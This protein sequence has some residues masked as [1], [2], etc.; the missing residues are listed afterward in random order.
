MYPIMLN[1][2]QLNIIVIGGGK[3]A[4]RKVQ[5][6]LDCGAQHITIVSDQLTPQLQS[7]VSQYQLTWQARLY[8]QGDII[9]FH[10]VLLCTN[11]TSVNQQIAQEITKEQ[12]FNDATNKEN[13]NFFNMPYFDIPE[14]VVAVST[15]GKNCST[16]KKIRNQLQAILKNS[17]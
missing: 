2:S 4:T 9:G 14:G 11:Q 3:I 10:M 12:L 6:L 1:I 5:A 15:F 16:S 17:Q 8:Q 13:S 7:L